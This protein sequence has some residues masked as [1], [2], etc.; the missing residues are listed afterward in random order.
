MSMQRRITRRS[1][2][3]GMALSA[4]LGVPLMLA[5]TVA[6]A[7]ASKSA[8]HYRDYPN[9]TQMC[10]TCRFFIPGGGMMGH[11]MMGHGMM[12]HGMMGHGMM[13]AG[14]CQVVEGRISPTGYCDLYAPRSA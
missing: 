14:A 5:T 10:R 1:W 2:L 12:G 4:V 8:V 9:G 11:G 3:K 6:E 7:K 13:G